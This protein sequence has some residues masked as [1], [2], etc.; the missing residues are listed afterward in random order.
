MRHKRY[1]SKAMHFGI[2][3][4]RGKTAAN[5]GTLWRSAVNLGADYIFTVGCR[6]P[7]QASDTV[8]AWK[9]V[10][11]F[12]YADAEDFLSHRP[13]DVPLI[14]VE[15]TEE[16]TPLTSFVHPMQAIYILGPEDGNLS[17]RIQD[18]CAA[19]VSIDSTYCLNVSVAGSIVMYDRRTKGLA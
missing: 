3:I 12:E 9:Q 14:G 11:A 8:R 6:Y 1:S 5:Y 16:P 2:G 7:K 4:E 13:Y 17:R 18:Q 15:L 10:P 19:V